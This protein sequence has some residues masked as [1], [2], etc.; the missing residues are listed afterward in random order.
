MAQDCFEQALPSSGQV[1][2]KGDQ[3]LLS[4]AKMTE[5]CATELTSVAMRYDK[6]HVPRTVAGVGM[7]FGSGL[8]YIPPGQASGQLPARV[9]LRPSPIT[10][11]SEPSETRLESAPLFS[12]LSL[13]SDI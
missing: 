7:R 9:L 6:T 1:V 3:A 8:G 2:A 11:P 12:V 4:M 5:G 13:V 10:S